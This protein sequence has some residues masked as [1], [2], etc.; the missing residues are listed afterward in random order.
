MRATNDYLALIPPLY[1]NKPNF[2]A[3]IAASVASFADVQSFFANLSQAFDLNVAVGAQ[4]D[5]VGQWV[6][7]SR[8]VTIPVAQPWF[9]WSDPLRGWSQGYWQGPNINAAYIDSLDDDTYRRLLYAKI[10]ANYGDGQTD[11]AQAALNAYFINPATHV[12]VED[13]SGAVGVIQPFS[14]GVPANGWGQ[15]YWR[16]PGEFL[17][18]TQPTLQTIG[19]HWEIGVSGQIPSVVDLEILAQKLIPIGPAGVYLDIKVVTVDNT[20]L[21]GWGLMNEFVSGWEVGSWGEPP[22]FVAQNIV[23]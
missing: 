21:F 20:P 2:N 17:G 8:K 14:W 4:L 1:A 5:V 10:I 13:V 6:G 19:M 23:S 22:D 16:A 11:S 7:Q 9:T 12:F 18:Q 15:A 3:T